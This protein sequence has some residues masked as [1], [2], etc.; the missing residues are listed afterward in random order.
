MAVVR[1]KEPSAAQVRTIRS[2]STGTVRCEVSADDHT[3]ITDEPQERGGT[4]TSAPPLLHLTAALATCQTVQIVKVA[5]AMR[6]SHGAINIEASTTTD[7]V[8]GLDGNDKVMRFCAADLK[9]DI[10]TDES[11]DRLERLKALSEDACP[12]G[13]LFTDAGYRPTIAWNTLPLKK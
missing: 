10:E 9:I 2:K 6:F 4:N 11:P 13:M 3:I 7:R 1:E 12:V 5:K 8:A